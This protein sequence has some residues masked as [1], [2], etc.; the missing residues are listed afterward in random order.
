MNRPPKDCHPS[1]RQATVNLMFMLALG[2]AGFVSII[3][4]QEAAFQT[5]TLPGNNVFPEGIAYDS[6][7][8]NFYV[9]SIQG[10]TVYRGNI[11]D[12]SGELGVF[13]PGG[14]DGRTS[15]TGLKVDAYGR[16][17]VAG[18]NTGRAFVYD[19]T[20]DLIKV[21]KTPPA[22]RTLLNDVTVTEDAA[23]FTDS[24]RPVVFRVPLTPESVGEMEAWLELRPTVIP[25]G[26]GFN[27]NGVAATADRRYLLSV[28][29]DSGRLYRID[30]RTKEVA[31]V[32]LDTRLTTGD[33]LWL[34]QQTLYI[35]RENPASVVIVELSDDFASGEVTTTVTHSSLDL[36]TTLAKAGDRLLIVNSQLDGTQPKLPF[37]VTSLPLENRR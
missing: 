5:Y 25:Y 27:L 12:G 23:Y 22:A 10:G 11:R 24:F 13:L 3:R 8:G 35:V 4:A 33:G 1:T 37:T 19:T 14:R 21:L 26:N 20:G 30:T 29:F 28:H 15:V 34:E 36:P 18:R 17:F 32:D 16:L 2:T 31:Q 9:G 7:T 6:A